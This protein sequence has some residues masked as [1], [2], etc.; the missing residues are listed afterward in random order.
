MTATG[1]PERRGLTMDTDPTGRGIGRRRFLTIGAA[2]CGMALMPWSGRAAVRAGALHDWQG[3]ALGADAEIRLAHP[4]PVE[5]RRLIGRCLEEVA[6][7]ERVFSLYRSD[8][9]LAR[10]NREGVLHDPPTDLVRLMAEAAAYGRMTGGAFDV[11]VQPLWQ[12][13]AGHFESPGADPSGPPAGAVA[14]TRRLVDWRAVSVTADRIA[15]GRRGMA[16]T[17]NGIAQGYITDRITDLLRQAGLRDVLVDMGEIR[18]IGRHPAGRPWRAALRNPDGSLSRDLVL[19]G[20]A[21]ATSAGVGTSFDS[22]GRFGHLLD[23][24]SARPA[25]RWHTV[26]VLAPTATRADALSTALSVMDAATAAR[27]LRTLPDVAARLVA[28][29]GRVILIGS[30]LKA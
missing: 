22:A 15:F 1:A 2:A 20:R 13:Y 4:D 17:L 23:P 30:G 3:T 29:D 10:L 6:R 18:A 24:G 25:A 14:A 16:A 9:T 8:S 21:L 12:L 7:L 19:D 11:T 5:A 26:S 28:L 27:L